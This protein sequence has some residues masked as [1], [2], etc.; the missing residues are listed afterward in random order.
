M[1]EISKKTNLLEQSMYK[2]SLQD[3][4]EP[5]LYRDLYSYDDIPKVA[6]NHRRV[7]MS[8][9]KEIWIT[10]TSL[11]DGQQSVEPYTVDQIVQLYKYM[12]KLG[13]PFGIIRQTEFFVYSKKDREALLKCQE[14]GLKFPEITTW[15]RAN[16][17]DFKLVRDLGIRET[18]ILVSCSDYH[19]FKKLKMTRRQ[20]LDTYLAA[21]S[22]AFE[23]GVMPRCHLEDITR[24]DFYGFVVPFVN[25][26]MNMSKEAGIPVRI[27]ACDTMGYG[28]P[29]S[30]V[31]LPRSVPG[32]IYGL[33]HY[34]DVPSEML[35]WHGHNDF[36]KSVANASTAWLYGASAVNCSLLGIGE[37]T[38]NIPLEA[39]VMEYASLRGSFDGMDPTVIT[40]I[41]EFFK[42]DM[43]YTIPPMTPFVGR[44]FNVTR[45]GIHADGL[46]K[47]EEI[48]NI[49]NTDK[50]LNR[51]VS[52]LLGK[53]SGLAGIAYWINQNYNLKGDNTVDKRSELVIK[54][55]EWI[56]KEYEDG[57]QTT[58]S[59]DEL[60]EKIAELSNGK[61]GG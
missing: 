35:E 34:S 37:R 43:G 7:P 29:Y 46:L 3:V 10:D 52:V 49:F 40:E 55:K 31:A 18:G 60:E 15:I 28:V 12:S 56:D 47:D 17:E 51:P 6:F 1:L 23:A 14:L 2:Y 13:G 21:V 53:A 8:M 39:M 20:A 33:Q 41:A 38:G 26:L 16:K 11:R 59:N 58:L 44:N 5:N 36:Y 48:Y 54:L 9:P 32:I 27:R 22:E 25:E 45:A 61:L 42:K 50:I 57:R 4:A 19:I 30:E 24:A